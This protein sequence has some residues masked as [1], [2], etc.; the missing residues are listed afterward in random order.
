MLNAHVARF[1]L[2]CGR[3]PVST[4]SP[5]AAVCDDCFA[6]LLAEAIREACRCP[7]CGTGMDMPDLDHLVCPACGHVDV[8]EDE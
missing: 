4:R 3:Q 7:K 6:D 8:I 5:H 2:R 1:C